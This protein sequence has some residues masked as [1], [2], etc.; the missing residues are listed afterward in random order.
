MKSRINRKYFLLIISFLLLF[1]LLMSGCNKI[2]YWELGGSL[3]E[4]E[5]IEVI[6]IKDFYRNDFGIIC[7]I[8]EDNYQ[9]I[10]NEVSNL[11]YKKYFGDPSCPRGKV[12]KI[13]F[14]NDNYDLISRSEPRH[15][16]KEGGMLASYITYLFHPGTEFDQLIE[17]WTTE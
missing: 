14:K 8:D 12:I 17:K 15:C 3:D 10:I 9:E 6:E 1:S 11:Q 5:K 2:Y 7:E 4:I 13:T 16:D